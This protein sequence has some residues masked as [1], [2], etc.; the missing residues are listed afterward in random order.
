[1]IGLNTGAAQSIAL[2]VDTALDRDSS[3]QIDSLVPTQVGQVP[4]KAGE[5]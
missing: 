4:R 1:M 5:R 3:I 2:T